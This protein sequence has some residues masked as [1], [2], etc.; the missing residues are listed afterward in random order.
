MSPRAP[1]T[2]TT[3]ALVL[4]VI[5]AVTLL[6]MAILSGRDGDN[7]DD[8]N[9]G[10][11]DGG[12]ELPRPPEDRPSGDEPDW[13]PDFERQFASYVKSRGDRSRRSPR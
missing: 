10:P 6:L 12:P 5:I 3:F 11:D 2:G 4:F 8:G 13:W 9:A 1:G 7:P